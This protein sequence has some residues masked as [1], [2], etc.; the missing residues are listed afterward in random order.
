M[1]AQ[2]IDRRWEHR[3]DVDRVDLSAVSVARRGRHRQRFMSDIN[4][5]TDVSA[6]STRR[7]S[8]ARGTNP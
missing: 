3:H 8:H 6:E 1:N 4:H 7:S 2:S 5:L